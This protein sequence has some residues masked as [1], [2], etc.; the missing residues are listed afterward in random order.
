MRQEH[1]HYA[2]YWGDR[3]DWLIAASVHRDSDT[4]DRANWAEW[5]KALPESGTV[6][7]E[8]STHW[9]VGW[10]DYLVIDPSDTAAVALAESLRER[11]EDYPVLDEMELSNLEWDEY[12]EGWDSYGASEFCRELGNAFDLAYATKERLGEVDSEE[13][14]KFFESLINSGEYYTPD[15]SGVSIRVDSA[16]FHC[17]RE[18]LGQF[19]RAKCLSHKT[20]AV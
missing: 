5:C 13:L 18:A 19:L 12:L 9:A 11:L 4:V 10:V 16:V 15:G 2:A 20:A 6:A 17:T 3:E 8:R 1:S 7:I 14:R